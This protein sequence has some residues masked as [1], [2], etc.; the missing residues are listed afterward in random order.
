MHH[1]DCRESRPDGIELGGL[2]DLHDWPDGAT[3]W[4][5]NHIFACRW[6]DEDAQRVLEDALEEL[7]E[8]GAVGTVEETPPVNV[9]FNT[10]D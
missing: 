3:R 5:S 10:G 7:E 4:L 1:I 6:L 2:G 8:A 9:S